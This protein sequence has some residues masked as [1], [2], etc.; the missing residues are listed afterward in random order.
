MLGDMTP[1]PR[2][3]DAAAV[4]DDG[5]RA[6]EFG[7]PVVVKKSGNLWRICCD[8]GRNEDHITSEVVSDDNELVKALRRGERAHEVNANVEKLCLW[9]R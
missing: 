2:L 8:G 7:K 5:V 3:E 9:N 1:N 4:G 6:A